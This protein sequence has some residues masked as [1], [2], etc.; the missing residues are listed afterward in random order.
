VAQVSA[1]R[2]RPL[3]RRTGMTSRPSARVQKSSSRSSSAVRER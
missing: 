2:T 3:S 1:P